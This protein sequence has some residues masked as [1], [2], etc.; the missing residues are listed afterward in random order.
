[1]TQWILKTGGAALCALTALFCLVSVPARSQ[2]PPLWPANSVIYT[3]YPAIFSPQGNFAGVTAQLPR[4][5][6]LGV[7]VL[8]LMPVTPV[9]EP[10]NGHPAFGSSYCVHNYFAVNPDYGTEGDLKTLVSTA[11]KLGLKV[12]LDEVLN[13]TAWDNPLTTQHPEWYVHT[14][15]NPKNPASIQQ[16]FTYGDVAQLNYANPDLRTYMIGMLQFWVSR[17]GVDG[18]RFDTASNPDSAN[19]MIPAD[20]WQ[21]AGQQLRASKPDI[22]LLGECQSADLALRPF[23]LDYGWSMYDA[24]KA[25]FNGGDATVRVQGSWQ[26]EQNAFPAGM[27]HMAI[28]DD[29]DTN[30]DVSAF[31]GA[32]G[33]QAAAV[34]HFT[35]VGVPLLY[36]GMEIGNAGEA[37][38]PHAPIDWANADPR[39][40]GFYPSLI[41]LRRKTPALQTGDMAWVTNSAPSQ[42]LTYTRSGGG[43]QFLVEINASNAAVSGTV[44]LPTGGAWTE[45]KIK[46][47]VG[48]GRAHA[49]PP[50]V[51]LKP[52]EFAVFQ[53]PQPNS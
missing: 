30:R 14:D 48:A 37:N 27:R 41:A 29:W 49:A 44:T 51:L 22:L 12:I 32:A 28:Q 24:L 45:V 16:A 23:P 43:Q 10:V 36:N 47:M 2:T 6:K 17:Y 40:A 9:G 35:S 34:F 18:F 13:H 4:L 19:R 42:V 38:N 26:Y 7:T 53:R 31:N 33:A 21:D 50:N 3:L 11:H 39:F 20:F 15:G 1:M 46:G 5:Q 52:K 8:W 25:A